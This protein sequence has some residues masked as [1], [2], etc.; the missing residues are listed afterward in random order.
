MVASV[1]P[2]GVRVGKVGGVHGP[3]SVRSE[4]VAQRSAATVLFLWCLAPNSMITNGAISGADIAQDPDALLGV[5]RTC[6]FC[7]SSKASCACSSTCSC[8]ACAEK[9]RIRTSL[10]VSTTNMIR[11]DS[12]WTAAMLRARQCLT[13]MLTQE[14]QRFAKTRCPRQ[15]LGV[16][17]QKSKTEFH[18]DVASSWRKRNTR[19]NT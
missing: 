3:E 10:T 9:I 8:G 7:R 17:G 4:D 11:D 14:H 15:S 2:R 18:R 13:Q 6:W 1:L 5:V 12:A 16:L 19:V